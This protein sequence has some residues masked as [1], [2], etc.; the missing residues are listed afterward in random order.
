MTSDSDKRRALV[1]GHDKIVAYGE[2]ALLRL[3]DVAADPEEKH[4]ITK[5]DAF[6]T[7]AKRYRE[8]AK[9]IKEVPPYQCNVGCLNRAYATKTSK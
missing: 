2:Q 9:E 5:G 3:Y 1:M 4:P 6:D 7:M 8:I